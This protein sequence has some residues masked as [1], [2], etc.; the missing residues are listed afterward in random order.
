MSDKDLIDLLL[1]LE[2]RITQ[3][4]NHFH[5]YE[6]GEQVWGGPANTEETSLPKVRG[7]EKKGKEE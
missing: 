6:R 5:I 3:L 2:A 1:R 4:E 7:S